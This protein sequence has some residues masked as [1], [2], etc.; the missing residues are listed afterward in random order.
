MRTQLLRGVLDVVA[1][2]LAH[3]RRELNLFTVGAVFR[4]AGEE[5]AL[6]DEPLHLLIVRT[7]PGG[8]SFWRGSTETV[9]LFEIKAEVE[10]VLRTFRPSLHAELVFDFE[11]SRGSFQY[12][13]RRH[14]VVE[15]GV[16]PAAAAAALDIDQPLWYAVIDVS[17]LY[18]ARAGAATFHPFA[19]FPAS[20][21]DLSLVAPR[22]VPWGQIEKHVAK[23]GGR[24][25]ESLQVFD[26]YQGAAL[27]D[28][29]AYGIRL[30]FRSADATLKDA[31]VDSIVARIV[32]KLEA[33]LGVVLRS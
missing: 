32:A 12:S 2:N 23:A 26:V 22:G 3:G 11:S 31:E 27:G 19:A 13:D 25:L 20:R 10:T 29:I 21:R 6:P 7:R 28:R 9:G 33:E 24:L 8:T 14:A 4:R 18:E 17:A 16:L 15:G 5:S 1:H 30:S